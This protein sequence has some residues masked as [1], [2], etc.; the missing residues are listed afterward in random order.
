M[1]QMTSFE[2]IGAARQNM[3]RLMQKGPVLMQ[4]VYEAI[5]PNETCLV[6]T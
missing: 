1:R 6:R 4:F 2:L 5:L 3:T